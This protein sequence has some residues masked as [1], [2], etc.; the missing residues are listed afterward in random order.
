MFDP[1]P[2][3][4]RATRQPGALGWASRLDRWDAAA[5][6]VG[7]SFTCATV[8]LVAGGG[9]YID[10]IRAQAYAADRPIWPFVVESNRTHLSPSA[11]TV[12]WLQAHYAPLQHWP[13]VVLTAV[14][15]V[16]LATALWIAVR[17]LIPQPPVA[18]LGL[19]LALGS[20]TL[21]PSLAWYRQALTGL[22][23]F[24]LV[25]VILILAVRYSTGGRWPLLVMVGVLHVVALGFSERALV[26]PVLLL[27]VLI[28]ARPSLRASL[29]GRGL[30]AV[31]LLAAINIAF[32]ATYLTGEYDTAAGARPSV[33]GFVLST[34]YSL[35]RNTVPAYLGGPWQWSGDGPYMY[36]ATPVL[37]ATIAVVAAL[38][39]LAAALRK[40]WR[41]STHLLAMAAAFM[42]PVYAMIYLGR[43]A[44]V[45]DITSVND[46]RLHSDAAIIGALCLAA[47]VGVVVGGD[48]SPRDDRA[49][50]PS[51]RTAQVAI[52]V[53][54]SVVVTGYVQSWTAFAR[55]WHQH[56]SD[57]YFATL[58]A[59]L[60][61]NG[62][63]VAPGPVPERIVPWW[64]QPDFSTQALVRLLSPATET[65]TMVPPVMAVAPDGSLTDARL[66]AFD[67]LQVADG[68]CGMAV[69]AG[70]DAAL[71]QAAAPIPARRHQ[72][73]EIGLLIGDTT[74]VA[75]AVVDDA[76]VEH[77]AAF[78]TPPILHRGPS[79]VLAAIPRDVDVVGVVVTALD[80]NPAG[81][82]ITSVTSVLAGA[83]L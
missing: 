25:I 47:L 81:M 17:W 28:L 35:F 24:A 72:M 78:Y 55:S 20:A 22:L 2:R 10:D 26:A 8:W 42:V 64:V 44:R 54:L 45:S 32:L 37:P 73:L 33:S 80:G 59:A 71:I 36:A 41:R 4:R 46:L 34:A 29:R 14:I 1:R 57:A 18:V 21:V 48:H 6:V 63:T 39:V 49:A 15:A 7:F 70:T 53:V 62:G 56:D 68:F 50:A 79:R 74:R 83:T 23:A 27:A 69:P 60:D 38:A 43:I 82:C 3:H 30:V 40:D 13:A 67:R 76:G 9:L 19:V 5:A 51:R 31:G 77:P 52:V 61:R 65:A 11:R 12:D 75:V 58:E 16:V 66:V